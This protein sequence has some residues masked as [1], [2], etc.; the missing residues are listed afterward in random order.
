M[1]KYLLSILSVIAFIVIVG[2]YEA[3]AVITVNSPIPTKTFNVID[4]FASS[5]AQTNY[6]T[7]TSATSTNII[8]YW[9]SN[10][11][12]DNGIAYINGANKATFYFGRAWDSTGNI[13]SSTFY[14]EVTPD[15]TNWYPYNKL[16]QN[17]STSTVATILPSV[18][19]TGTSTTIT[20]MDLQYDTFLGV[21]C[22]V[23]RTTDGAATCRVSISFP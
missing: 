4:F 18:V 16:I 7:S 22:K 19:V 3:K 6:A 12:L 23:V 21:R 8:S 2:T 10:G 14:V 20:S 9:D 5:T 13:G 15:G 17:L 11:R 1:K